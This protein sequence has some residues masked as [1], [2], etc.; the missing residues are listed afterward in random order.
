MAQ[1][2]AD[3][4]FTGG[5]VH[6]VDA[7]N[8]IAEAVAVTGDRISAVGS[9]AEISAMAGAGTRRVD[10]NGR[11]LMP[12][13]IDAHHHFVGV[14]GAEEAID[15]KA[16][17]MQGIAA[18]QEA[19]R[20]RAASLPAGHM[21]S[22]AADTTSPRLAEQRH[23]NRHD[24]DAVAPEHPVVFT[25]TC[26]HII[27]FNTKAMEVAGLAFDT[28][29]PDGGRF[30][31]DADGKIA[32]VAYE[33]ANATI[34]TAATPSRAEIRRWIG[35]ANKADPRQWSDQHP[36]CGRLYG[37]PPMDIATGIAGT[38]EL[39]VRVYAFTTV[40]ALDHPHVGILNTGVH[41]G[42]GNDRLRIGAFK[43]MTDGSSSG[44]NGRHARAVHLQLR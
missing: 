35:A 7:Q 43:V 37:R 31:R 33:R 44:P 4:I 12:G 36:R 5:N 6:T 40:N 14:G 27:A 18:I 28:P 26:G 42:F 2:A 30:D 32:G 39:Q 34:S 22:R 15:C 3:I 19:V 41:T 29:D 16:P 25:R 11:S 10:L 1:D 8:S 9:N 38:D 13:F 23:P 20:Q 21:D 17:G 24:F